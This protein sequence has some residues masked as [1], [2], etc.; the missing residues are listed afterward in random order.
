MSEFLR[1]SVNAKLENAP[2]PKSKKIYKATD[3]K[4]LF[5]INKIGN[6]LNQ[7]ARQLNSKKDDISNIEILK[8]LVALE[9]KMNELV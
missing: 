9:K 5:E 2:L 7:I 8:E 6:N 1:N 3:P 4:L